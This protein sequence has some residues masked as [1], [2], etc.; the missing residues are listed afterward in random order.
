MH[1]KVSASELG[2]KDR[3]CVQHMIKNLSSMSSA[4]SFAKKDVPKYRGMYV[5]N[6]YVCMYVM[7]RYVVFKNAHK[8]RRYFSQVFVIQEAEELSSGAQAGL[9][10]TL[11]RYVKN[12][13][14]FLHCQQL[15]AVS[16]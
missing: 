16:E 7:G 3:V 1:H 4:F 10:R 8:T 15:S 14:V 13:R 2:N 5:C 11:E 6:M 12:S 9:R